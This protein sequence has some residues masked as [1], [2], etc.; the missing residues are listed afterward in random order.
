MSVPSGGLTRSLERVAD[1]ICSYRYDFSLAEIATVFTAFTES[2]VRH[3]R[4]Y[5]LLL[6]DTS[7]LFVSFSSFTHSLSEAT[8]RTAL[9]LLYA[10]SRAIKQ[11]MLSPSDR[12]FIASLDKPISEGMDQSVHEGRVTPRLSTDNCVFL[13]SSY[14][15]LHFYPQNSLL[16]AVRKIQKS[17]PF[18]S[19]DQCFPV[20][21]AITKCKWSCDG[22]FRNSYQ[23][24]DL[25]SCRNAIRDR[26][27]NHMNETPASSSVMSNILCLLLRSSIS[28][29]A[30]YWF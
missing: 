8:P 3:N 24:P 22:A 2:E 9:S 26:Y 1:A 10:Y 13:L 5:H 18:L 7:Q 28:V 11:K 4:L 16:S 19:D 27:I 23:H 17:V 14:N 30:E 12:S 6:K 29:I 21:C 15:N 25:D 20:L